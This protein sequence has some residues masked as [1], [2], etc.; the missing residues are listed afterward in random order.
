M[1]GE[2][3]MSDIG[4]VYGARNLPQSEITRETVEKEE[5]ALLFSQELVEESFEEG[6]TIVLGETEERTQD[7]N[8]T[9]EEE[10]EQIRHDREHE[11]QIYVPDAENPHYEDYTPTEKSDEPVDESKII[12]AGVKA[13]ETETTV[14][15]DY[16]AKWNELTQKYLKEAQEKGLSGTDA[17][18]YVQK[19]RSSEMPKLSEILE[20]NKNTQTKPKEEVPPA[21]KKP[22]DTPQ[23]R[24]QKPETEEKPGNSEIPAGKC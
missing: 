7:K 1:K 8:L 11:G 4:K 9:D 22:A 14:Y 17:T 23:V 5:Q 24:E 13:P 12:V 18:I 20:E 2:S 21:S 19:H 10:A 15:E 16:N 6:D 3:L